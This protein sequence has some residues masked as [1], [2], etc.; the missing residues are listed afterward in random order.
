MR[1]NR[2]RHVAASILT[3]ILIGC[4]PQLPMG[5]E[6]HQAVPFSSLRNWG[7]ESFT[8]ISPILNDECHRIL[9]LQGNA[10]V[11]M[12][13]HLLPSGN[14]ARDW[15]PVCHAF[16]SSP[17][18]DNRAMQTFF[19]TWFTPYYINGEDKVEGFSEVVV[20]ASI[21]QTETYNIPVYAKPQDLVRSQR[22]G[23][24]W[25]SGR[26]IGTRFVPFFSRAEIDSGALKGKG[27]EIAWVRGPADLFMLQY[28]GAGRLALADG[29]TIHIAYAARNGRPYTPIGRILRERNYISD[30]EITAPAIR[31]WMN[32]Y[33]FQARQLMA[34]NEDYVFFESLPT[35]SLS[36]GSPGAMGIGVTPYRSLRA[37]A[38][39]IPFGAPVWVE[40]PMPLPR[41]GRAPWRHLAFMQD[42]NSG[43]SLGHVAMFTGWGGD[44]DHVATKLDDRGRLFVLLP[45]PTAE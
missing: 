44:A 21:H 16:L 8:Q 20:P 6:S 7:D 14:F 17:P 37:S 26:W 18:A 34:Q 33:P 41:G 40:T 2:A 19:E 29:R 30:D 43:A 13:P 35:S 39:Y 12:G 5:S 9:A 36:T 15:R 27:L 28:N 32:R 11:N 23:G 25:V 45:R 42:V 31:N 10:R 24:T 38:R 22:S 4:A 1:T 3:L